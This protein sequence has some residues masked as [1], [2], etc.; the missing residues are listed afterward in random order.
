MS[1]AATLLAVCAVAELGLRV[2]VHWLRRTCPW[3]IVAADSRPDLDPAGVARFMEHGWDAQLGWVRKPGTAHDETGEGGRTTRYHIDE[4]GARRSPGFEG[5]TPVVLAYGDSYTFARQV[6]DDEAWPHLLGVALGGRVENRGV[7]NYGLDQ[8]LLRL[9]RE[10]DQHPA[11]VVVMGV[12]PETIC[13]VLS[14]WKHYSEYGNLFAFKPRFRLEGGRLDVLPNPVP[15]SEDFRDISPIL[16]RL[17]ADDYFYDRKFRQD[18]LRFP[19]LW[20]LW[21]SR[22]RNVPLI[23]AAVADRLAGG[24]QRAFCRVMDRNIKM[25]ADLYA[26]P[27]AL[28]LMEAL[29]A[30][31]ATFCRERGAQPV[32]AM[33]PQL[34]DL[35]H[36]GAA[37]TFYQGFL[38]RVRPLVT[39]VDFGPVFVGA[40]EQA[41][42]TDDRFGGHFSARGNRMVAETLAPIL[43]SLPVSRGVHLRSDVS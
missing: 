15:R 36:I 8:A 11:P 35:R 20:H 6:N 40:S 3:L 2:L 16:P 10:Y 39:V 24:G 21:R 1:L 38:D 17:M 29:T 34:Y 12:V 33:F 9:E 41:C 42:Y 4:S 14:V 19:Y 7:G 37:G 13:R 31:F 23:G 18:Q 32:L 27:Q 28:D 26:D 43:R 25:A 5:Q 30:R 22:H